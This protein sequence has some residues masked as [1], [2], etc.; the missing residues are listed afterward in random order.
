M[1]IFSYRSG[2]NQYIHIQQ[3]YCSSVSTPLGTFYMH[4]VARA[5]IQ[6]DNFICLYPRQIKGK[7]SKQ[8]LRITSEIRRLS[9]VSTH[10]SSAPNTM[11]CASFTAYYTVFA[12]LLMCF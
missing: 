11:D 1:K 10:K 6:S 4:S 12:L 9:L 7:V 2:I 8:L 3:G 5:N